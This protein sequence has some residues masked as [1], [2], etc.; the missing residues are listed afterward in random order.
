MVQEVRCNRGAEW[1]FLIISLVSISGHGAV[2]R[3]SEAVLQR[4]RPREDD[5]LHRGLWA[6][7]LNRRQKNIIFAS[8]MM[9]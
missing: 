7:G 3:A 2:P 5:H 8:V 1:Y 4:R 9:R 6:R